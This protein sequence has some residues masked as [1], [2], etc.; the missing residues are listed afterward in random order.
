[1]DRVLSYQLGEK[2]RAKILHDVHVA[3]S[4][5]ADHRTDCSVLSNTKRSTSISV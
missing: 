1:M 2:N 5:L 3:S 4:V